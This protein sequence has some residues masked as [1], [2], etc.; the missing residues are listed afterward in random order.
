M[1]RVVRDELALRG[2]VRVAGDVGRVLE[3]T[4]TCQGEDVVR[5]DASLDRAGADLMDNRLVQPLYST[6]S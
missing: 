3:D 5:V 6:C 2:V 4:G 1:R